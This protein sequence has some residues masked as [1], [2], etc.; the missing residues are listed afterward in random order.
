MDFGLP[1]GRVGGDATLA[2]DGPEGL[3]GAFDSAGLEAGGCVGADLDA[4][5]FV[6]A[7]D[8]LADIDT[9]QKGQSSA[10]SSRTDA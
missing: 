7:T 5:G 3:A 6:G 1:A 4:G 2:S 8:R 9:P 10:S